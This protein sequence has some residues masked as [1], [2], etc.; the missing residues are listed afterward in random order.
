M[1]PLFCG[2]PQGSPAS[3]ILYLLYTEPIHRLGE[4]KSHYGYA[5]DCGMLAIADTVEESTRLA[6][7]MLTRVLTWGAEN[8]ISFGPSKTE[9]PRVCVCV[10]VYLTPV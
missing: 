4:E 8:A 9:V 1:E 5:D 3:P 10:C 2:L 6:Q 7:D